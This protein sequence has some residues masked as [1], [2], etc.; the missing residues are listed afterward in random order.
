MP[1]AKGVRVKNMSIG[2]LPRQIEMLDRYVREEKISSKSEFIRTALDFYILFQEALIEIGGHQRRMDEFITL[3]V[4]QRKKENEQDF[5][6]RNGITVL[7]E[8]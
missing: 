5:L 2:L 6:E 7:R 8:A 4:S 1:Q 3:P